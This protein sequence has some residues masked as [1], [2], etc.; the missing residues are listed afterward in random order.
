[1]SQQLVGWLVSK[2]ASESVGRLFV[3]KPAN[4]SAVSWLVC[5]SAS[6]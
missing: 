2:P 5:W 1:M 6:Q 4:E 3:S